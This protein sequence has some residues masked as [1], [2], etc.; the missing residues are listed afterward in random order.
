MD[1]HTV[2]VLSDY[3][4]RV[5]VRVAVKRLDGDWQLSLLEVTVGEPPPGWR[6]QRFGVGTSERSIGS[7]VPRA[8]KT[9]PAT[10][11]DV[12][13]FVETRVS[14]RTLRSDRPAEGPAR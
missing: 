7:Y 13:A 9:F 11:A 3:E 10:P 8:G 1:R 6:R 2:S 14:A 5:W 12:R 4:P